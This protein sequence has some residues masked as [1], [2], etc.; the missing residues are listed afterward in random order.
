RQRVE[1]REGLALTL[2]ADDADDGGRP[3][4]LLAEGLVQYNQ[5]EKCWV[6]AIDW[7]AIRHESQVKIGNENGKG[8]RS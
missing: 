7:N 5:A 4:K 1:L 8:A 3:D 6:A 2:Y